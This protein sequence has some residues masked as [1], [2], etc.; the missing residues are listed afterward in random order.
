MTLPRA[1]RANS[2][3]ARATP[4][5]IIPLSLIRMVRESL[6]N[7]RMRWSFISLQAAVVLIVHW[8]VTL[9]VARACREKVVVLMI[10]VAQVRACHAHAPVVTAPWHV[11]SPA[12][13]E[14]VRDKLIPVGDPLALARLVRF[15]HLRVAVHGMHEEAVARFG[16]PAA[17]AN[18][19]GPAAVYEFV[20][21]VTEGRATFTYCL[22]G[23]EIFAGVA[24]EEALR[25][26]LIA[27]GK[28]AH[29]PGR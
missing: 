28:R 13:N 6:T 17:R 5:D 18:T 16:A 20:P 8:A 14:R 29:G 3:I 25:D 27:L 26:G 10:M 15:R 7:Q 2:I 23:V 21:L 19:V 1:R 12:A 11:T 22:A 4:L 24:L 9:E